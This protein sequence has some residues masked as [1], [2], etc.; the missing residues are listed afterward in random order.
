MDKLPTSYKCLLYIYDLPPGITTPVGIAQLVK[1]VT[2]Y[3][4]KHTPQIWRDPSKPFFTA[5]I[6]IE[7]D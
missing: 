6:K 4:L 1:Q 3:D 2:G 7:D 5:C